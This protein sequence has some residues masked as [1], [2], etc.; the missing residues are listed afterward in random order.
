MKFDHFSISLCA[1]Y[2][3]LPTFSGSEQR[4]C[5]WLKNKIDPLLGFG[6][7]THLFQNVPKGSKR[8]QKVPKCSK[9]FR[10]L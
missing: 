1:N 3:V 6:F 4:H 7:Q 8:F 9:P 10:A 2:L 5:D